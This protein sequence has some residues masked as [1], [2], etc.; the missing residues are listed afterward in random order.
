MNIVET[1]LAFK[2]LETLGRPWI[3]LRL[4]GGRIEARCIE[5]ETE[6]GIDKYAGDDPLYAF[7]REFSLDHAECGN[8]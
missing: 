5:C 2:T 6:D 1:M 8:G 3:M 4:K 7:L